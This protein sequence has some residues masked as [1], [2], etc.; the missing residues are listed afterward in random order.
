MNNSDTTDNS[1]SRTIVM[2]DYFK[3]G[4]FAL[5]IGFMVLALFQ[6]YFLIDDIIGMWFINRYIPVFKAL[7]NLVVFGIS[8]YIIRLYLIKR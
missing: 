5:A 4:V 2:E 3:K 8:L 6:I 1:Q 7:F